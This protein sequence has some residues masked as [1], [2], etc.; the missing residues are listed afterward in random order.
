[1][2]RGTD[3]QTQPWPLYS[4]RPL[5]LT[6]NRTIND[7]IDHTVSAPSV[8]AFKSRFKSLILVNFCCSWVVELKS[9]DSISC[10]FFWPSI[11]SA[12]DTVCFLV[13]SI[14]LIFS[15]DEY[16]IHWL[17]TWQTAMLCV[18]Y[19]Y[20]SC[21]PNITGSIIMWNYLVSFQ[22]HR[23]QR[24]LVMNYWYRKIS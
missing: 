3:R 22:P 9:M 7:L 8:I 14:R 19:I 2:R 4:S 21:I 11:P 15:A 20:V 10:Q 6:R 5:R 12:V 16:L 13:F 1:M 23:L 17:C 18:W 24:P